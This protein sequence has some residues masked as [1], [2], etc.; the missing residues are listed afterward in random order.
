MQEL[1]RQT[2]RRYWPMGEIL[3]HAEAEAKVEALLNTFE[4]LR[5]EAVKFL[6]EEA[7]LD[8]DTHFD[9][10]FTA[11]WVQPPNLIDTICATLEDY[12]QDYNHLTAK[13]YEYVII[14]GRNLVCKR[15]IGAML[16][17]RT[18][19]K[20]PEEI[21]SAGQNILRESNKIKS[22][23]TRMAPDINN[24]DWPFEIINMLAEVL[25]CL[26]IDM[27]SLDLHGLLDKCPDITEDHLVRLLS[28]RGD[29][30]K[31]EIKERVSYIVNSTKEKRQPQ[32]NSIFDQIVFNDRLLSHYKII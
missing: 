19:F 17:K 30:P 14:E 10:L 12:F 11:K 26:D 20:T 21:Q 16:S 18:T 2:E 24:M 8:L 3:N 32:P 29:I 31:G 1:A 15:Y 4:N 27:L 23:F 5:K 22:F 9:D 25:K 13:N 28:L 6:L 7:F